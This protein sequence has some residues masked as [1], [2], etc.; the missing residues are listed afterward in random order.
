MAELALVAASSPLPILAAPISCIHQASC[1]GSQPGTAA[2]P[3]ELCSTQDWDIWK[4]PSCCWASLPADHF[5][6]P[7]CYRATW[8][9]AEVG[10]GV[11]EAG[12]YG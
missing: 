10:V 11:W 12:F 9:G 8:K 4:W 6:H 2:R 5:V 1:P 7:T 3:A